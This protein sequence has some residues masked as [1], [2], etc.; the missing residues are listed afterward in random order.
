MGRFGALDGLIMLA[1]QVGAVALGCWLARL[2][3]RAPGGRSSVRAASAA[4]SQDGHRP[5]ATLRPRGMLLLGLYTYLAAFAAHIAAFIAL[6][7]LAPLLYA[8][9]VARRPYI[10]LVWALATGLTVW[11]M[12]K[13]ARGAG[14]DAVRASAVRAAVCA[15]LAAAAYYAFVALRG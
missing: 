12:R 9:R 11:L 13:R 14:A 6:K 3:R 8:D 4:S 5:R 1:L 7:H 15:I 10:A 2:L